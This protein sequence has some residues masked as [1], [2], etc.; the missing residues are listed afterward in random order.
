MFTLPL[1]NSTVM[2]FVSSGSIDD[3]SKYFISGKERTDHG[4][5][6]VYLCDC[7]WQVRP[8]QFDVI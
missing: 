7:L 8:F 2:Y 6:I 3:S 4:D 1:N 5:G